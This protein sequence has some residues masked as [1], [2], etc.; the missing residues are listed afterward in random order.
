MG[1]SSPLYR[2]GC[3]GVEADMRRFSL[4]LP[5]KQQE[6]SFTMMKWISSHFLMFKDRIV[7][8][9]GHDEGGLAI[10]AMNA[11]GE[12]MALQFQSLAYH[13]L[14]CPFPS[15]WIEE[16]FCSF[17]F[18]FSLFFCVWLSVCTA[19]NGLLPL[20]PVEVDSVVDICGV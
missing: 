12:L 6:A 8:L 18:A 4:S 7:G 14:Q 15:E 13:E 16:V 2:I 5:E 19:L 11:L 10:P 9:I 20:K 17:L 1:D 3:G